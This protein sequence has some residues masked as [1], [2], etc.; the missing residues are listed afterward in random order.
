MFKSRFSFKVLLIIPLLILLLL[1]DETGYA[2]GQTKQDKE[3]SYVMT[4][5]QLQSQL[6]SFADSF[7]ATVGSAFG[8][9]DLQ[10]PPP[11]E[12][13][14]L[15]NT[16][17]YALVSAF[18][19]AA[20][21]NPNAALL[22]MVSMISLGR[23]IYEEKGLKKYGTRI[24]P[25]LEA[26]RKAE[27]DIWRLAGRVLTPEQQQGFKAIIMEWHKANPEVFH[28]SYIRFSEFTAEGG[29][30]KQANAEWLLNLLNLFS[31]VE[32]ATQKV[33]DMRLVAE[34]GIYLG[35]RF[36]L[37]MTSFIDM[38]LSRLY[39]NPEIKKTMGDAHRFS[40]SSERFA[41]VAEKLSDQIMGDVHRFSKSSERLANV[42][43]KLP[44][45]IMGDVH[46]FSESSE[47]LANVAEKL[48]DQIKDFISEEQGMEGLL[49]KLRQTLETGNELVTSTNILIDRL[50]SDQ[51]E[52]GETASPAEPFNI[53]DYQAT[54]VEA[55]KTIQQLDRLIKT[56]DQIMLSPG[57]EQAL[58]RI[59]E[60]FD[61]VG[62]VGDKRIT[63]AFFLGLAF[64]LIFLVGQFFTFLAYRYASLRL[65]G[66]MP[67]E[68]P[69]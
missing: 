13:Y 1:S 49:K 63:H 33:E 53:K 67:K 57:W 40:E 69:S 54:L 32:S 24:E 30:S 37:M 62:A 65:F 68:S 46:R 51:A 12:R 56:F 41:N 20:D 50:N 15:L 18:T 48:P 44:D 5:L 43:E 36:P 38:S 66:S 35:T 52:P 16:T 6:M 4:E 31:S 8:F 11:D 22:D 2:A 59:V 9:Y 26:F 55:S 28:F 10:T 23:I 17:A 25:I 42:A 45:Q 29:K 64:I 21:D 14:I 58:P 7:A 47:R 19:I 34:R 3:K 61:R 60:A 39:Q 27:K